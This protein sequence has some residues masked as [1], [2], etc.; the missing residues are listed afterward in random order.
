MLIVMPV[1]PAMSLFDVYLATLAPAVKSRTLLAA[2]G[3]PPPVQLPASLQIVLAA[4]VQVNVAGA[5][6]SSRNSMRTRENDGRLRGAIRDDLETPMSK[7][8]SHDLCDI[9][10]AS[11]SK[12]N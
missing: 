3:T 6:R 5:V 10:K 12:I 1:R 4:P 8:L 2:L 11:T 9:G 7:R